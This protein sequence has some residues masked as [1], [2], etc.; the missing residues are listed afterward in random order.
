MGAHAQ[1]QGPISEWACADQRLLRNV[2]PDNRLRASEVRALG[3]WA[4]MVEEILRKGEPA[5]HQ[6]AT[7]AQ[8]DLSVLSRWIQDWTSR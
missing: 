1:F 7:R 5:L 4:A 6:A 2:I 3:T 8:V